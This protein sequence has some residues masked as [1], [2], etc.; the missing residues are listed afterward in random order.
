MNNFEFEEITLEYLK[1]ILNDRNFKL[2]LETVNSIDKLNMVEGLPII[3]LESLEEEII[4]IIV[5]NE[6]EAG[7]NLG[8]YVLTRISN[9]L[10]TKLYMY[11]ITLEDSPNLHVTIN[12]VFN[13]LNTI[14]DLEV[15]CLEE[16]KSLIEDQE[17]TY[18]DTFGKLCSIYNNVSE[19]TMI[20]ATK[21]VSI[22][23]FDDLRKYILAKENTHNKELNMTVLD[24]LSTL[25]NKY[26]KTG[27]YSDLIKDGYT[28][29]P[30]STYLDNMY[31]YIDSY[32][33]DIEK[34]AY[35]VAAT[36][37]IAIDTRFNLMD[38]LDVNFNIDSIELLNNNN[39]NLSETSDNILN[40]INKLLTELESRI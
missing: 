15:Y 27:I 7:S 37:Y 30:I 26:K 10:K 39:V 12:I 33:E 1:N 40:Y 35:E 19:T 32:G 17:Y 25:D 9:I 6:E 24:Q 16:I 36:L 13:T 2:L 8:A 14:Y 20:E 31:N 11:G 18:V 28:D 4:N 29:S 23:F 38:A 22:D 34:I 21:A 5:E 3:N